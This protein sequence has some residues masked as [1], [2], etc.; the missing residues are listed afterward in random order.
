MIAPKG[1]KLTPAQE[2]KAYADATA[3][4]KGRCVR[5][6]H[7]GPT[8]RDHRQ[9]R[10]PFNT[11]PANLQ[12]LGGAFGCGCHRWKTENPRLAILEGFAVPRYARPELWPGW[13]V[14]D[15]WVIYFDAPDADGNWWRKIS[16]S[17]AEF[18]MS[19]GGRGNGENPD[20]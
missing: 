1:E 19:S 9:N 16:E 2:K 8:E 12:L 10:D 11:T 18:I 17:T 13:R 7:P 14:D 15:G 3:R 20:N 4:D 5:C 6:G